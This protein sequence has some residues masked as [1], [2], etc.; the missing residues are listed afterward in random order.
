MIPDQPSAL[1]GPPLAEEARYAAT[2][3]LRLLTAA[4][5]MRITIKERATFLTRTTDWQRLEDA[6]RAAE[7]VLKPHN[8]VS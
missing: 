2:V 1:A 4:S 6:M 3:L 5:L 7:A 8:G